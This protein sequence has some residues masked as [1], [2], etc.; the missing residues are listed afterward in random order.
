MKKKSK[1]CLRKR[2]PKERAIDKGPEEVAVHKEISEGKGGELE[3]ETAHSNGDNK[4]GGGL[5]Q[6]KW[7]R[8]NVPA[9]KDYGGIPHVHRNQN[10][11]K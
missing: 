8:D 7:S 6:K 4:I 10:H 11:L 5:V 9:A 2:S 1:A 3:K